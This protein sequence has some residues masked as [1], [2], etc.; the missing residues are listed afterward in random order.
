MSIQRGDGNLVETCVVPERVNSW[1]EGLLLI[2]EV[3]VI[4]VKEI[5]PLRSLEY[6]FSF[7]A[8]PKKS[9]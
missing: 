4:Y 7:V 5:L 1:T 2:I 3:H 9:E 6:V 8:E